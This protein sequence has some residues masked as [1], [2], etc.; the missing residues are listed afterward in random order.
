MS[1]NRYDEAIQILTERFGRDREISVATL[2]RNRPAVRLVN[3]YFEDGSFYVVTYALSDKMRQVND[4]PEVAVCGEWFTAHGVGEN[5]GH[6]LDGR[7]AGIMVKLRAAFAGWY[8]N[9]HTD[10]SD[11][12]TCVLRVRLTDGVLFNQGTRYDIDFIKFM[13]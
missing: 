10:E 4:N 12:N 2:D 1:I 5:L 13:A 8:G 7:N 6:V 9:G 11:P 3:G